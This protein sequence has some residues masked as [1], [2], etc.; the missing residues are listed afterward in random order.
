MFYGNGKSNV[1]VI[2]MQLAGIYGFWEDEVLG[3]TCKMDLTTK[4]G[5]VLLVPYIEGAISL[6]ETLGLFNACG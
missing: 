2:V 4:R 6:Y 1:F 5:G 3:I